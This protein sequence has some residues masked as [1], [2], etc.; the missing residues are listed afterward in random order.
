MFRKRDGQMKKE[1][2]QFHA[3]VFGIEFQQHIQMDFENMIKSGEFAETEREYRI[4][5]DTFR[6]ILRQNQHDVLTKLERLQTEKR[7]YAAEYAFQCG[8]A[9]ICEQFFTNR[10]RFSFDAALNEGLFMVTGMKRHPEY[11]DLVSEVRKGYD[12]LEQELDE[13]AC[14][15]LA[16]HECA[17]D[18]RIYYAA[19]TGYYDGYRVGLALLDRICP[20]SAAQMMDKVRMTEYE[21]GITAPQTYGEKTREF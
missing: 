17:W 7:S 12:G 16:G 15:H 14:E 5:M 19:I 3:H 4:A 10:R 21:L 6:D 1:W 20:L 13:T 11:A 18:Q 2:E 9:A 8:V